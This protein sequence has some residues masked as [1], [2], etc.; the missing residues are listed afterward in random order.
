M[1]CCGLITF[2][3]QNTTIVNLKKSLTRTFRSKSQ[4]ISLKVSESQSSKDIMIDKCTN[5]S[6]TTHK[7]SKSLYIQ[8]KKECSQSFTPTPLVKCRQVNL[9][10]KRKRPNLLDSA[11]L[12]IIKPVIYEDN[13]DLE[14]CQEIFNSKKKE[15]KA[16]KVFEHGRKRSIKEFN[17]FTKTKERIALVIS[18]NPIFN[19]KRNES[20]LDI[21]K[22][23]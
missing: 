5:T 2:F 17:E 21:I 13:S 23:K 1:A 10:Q 15:G 7:V 18:N 8:D 4:E 20:S 9:K 16:D 3:S 6:R 19:L 12:S 14:I 11:S 22:E